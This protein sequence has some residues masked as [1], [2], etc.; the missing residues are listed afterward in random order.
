MKYVFKCIVMLLCFA[1][2]TSFTFCSKDD[3]GNTEESI[4]GKWKVTQHTWKDSEIVKIDSR[5]GDIWE[6]KTG[7]IVIVNGRQSSY[8]VSGNDITIMGGILYGSISTLSKNKLI[9]NLKQ[10]ITVNDIPPATEHIE[11][12]RL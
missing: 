7:G 9:L 8:S 2:I 5:I 1:S 12:T 6:F 11:F 4:V 3:D 10:G